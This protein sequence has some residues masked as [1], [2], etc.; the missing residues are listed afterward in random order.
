MADSSTHCF[1]GP[2]TMHLQAYLPSCCEIHMPRM[3]SAAFLCVRHVL[4]TYVCV[5][6]S[7][8]CC[9]ARPVLCNLL[10]LKTLDV[11]GVAKRSRWFSRRPMLYCSHAVVFAPACHACSCAG[12]IAFSHQLTPFLLHITHASVLDTLHCRTNSLPSY[13]RSCMFVCWIHEV[14]VGVLGP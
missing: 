9:V 2:R 7:S 6:I 3:A 10:R 13:C 12:D 1:F 4:C 5:R 14:H 11:S 8:Y